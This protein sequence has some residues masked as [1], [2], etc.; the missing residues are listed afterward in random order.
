MLIAAVAIASCGDDVT[1]DSD[2]ASSTSTSPPTETTPGPSTTTPRPAD[3]HGRPARDDRGHGQ[4]TTTTGGTGA[5]DTVTIE[6]EGGPPFRDETVVAGLDYEP[7]YEVASPNCLCD[8]LNPDPVEGAYC[9]PE[10]FVAGAAAADIDGDGFA[11]LF[12]AHPYD[13]D[14]IFHNNGDGTFTDVSE[15]MGLTEVHGTAGG[16]LADVDNDG[17]LD[18]YISTMGDVQN[19][20]YINHDGVF[21]DETYERRAA[22]DDGLQHAGTTPGFGDFDLDGDL[23]LWVGEW[24]TPGLSFPEIPSHA[25]L[26]RNMGPE[27]PGY[28]EDVTNEFG[29]NQDDT[30]LEVGANNEGVFVYSVAFADIDRDRYPDLMLASDFWCTRVLWGTPD[31]KF[32][33]GTDASNVVD[34]QNGMGSTLADWDAD[35]DLDWYITDIV[36]SANSGNRLYR[37]DG[38]REFTNVTNETGTRS[39]GNSEW[40]WGTAFLDHDNDGDMDLVATNGWFGTSTVE[41]PMAFWDNDGN[42]NMTPAQ[43]ELGLANTGNGRGLIV[44]DADNDGDMDMLV[45]NN[46]DSPIF[47]RNYVEDQGHW[48]RVVAPGTI[49]NTEGIGAQITVFDGEKT[50]YGEVGATGSHFLGHAPRDVHFGLGE[51]TTVDVTI[52]WPVSDQ[53]VVMKD[54]DVDQILTVEEPE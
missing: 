25:K 51:A 11:D 17:D 39:A 53:T 33:D 18:L 30:Y 14:Y 16:A 20:L 8:R 31:D 19:Y 21:V 46:Y 49:S 3:R 42:G 29:V 10:R 43:E 37:Y 13:H 26:L 41:D 38:N 34:T 4:D 1:G 27:L 28:F 9:L 6:G 45:I 47:Y 44:F 50:R 35:G 40:S 5:D 2:T 15:E 24:R 32:I 23:D 22:I 36:N 54:V 12:I 52:Y 7:P 48:L